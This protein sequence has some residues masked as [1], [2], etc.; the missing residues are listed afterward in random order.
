MGVAPAVPRINGPHEQPISLSRRD[1]T[2][3]SCGT[4][5]FGSDHI[6]IAVIVNVPHGQSSRHMRLGDKGVRCG[7]LRNPVTR[8]EAMS[9]IVG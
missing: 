9:L 5:H 1:I 2:E 7:Q 8:A 4:V 6:Q 3:D